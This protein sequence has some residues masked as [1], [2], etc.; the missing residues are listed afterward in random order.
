MGDNS[1]NAATGLSE[2]AQEDS[3]I[4]HFEKFEAILRD[5][6]PEL[7][8]LLQK[9]GISIFLNC[10][11]STDDSS[12]AAT[13]S[14]PYANDA[15]VAI[16]KNVINIERS[17]LLYSMIAGALSFA[18]LR[19]APRMI[20]YRLGSADKIKTMVD[21]EKLR[22]KTWQGKFGG[23]V[24]FVFE[25]FVGT[26]IG[27]QTYKFIHRQRIEEGEE[28]IYQQLAQIPLV[29]GEST[30]SDTLCAVRLNK[31]GACKS[32]GRILIL[33][34]YLLKFCTAT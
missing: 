5:K 25:T 14:M 22:R 4:S 24:S 20:V 13:Q 9:N 29:E 18:S 30:V 32:C 10:S 34:N 33:N 3:P 28:N 15:E 2:Q 19:Y 27:T 26:Y 21:G 23:M 16:I 31:R 17:A 11:S 6:F 12:A 1:S 8:E 7:K